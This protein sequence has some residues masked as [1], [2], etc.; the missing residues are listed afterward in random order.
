MSLLC[1][2][3]ILETLVVLLHLHRTCE[4]QAEENGQRIQPQIGEVPRRKNLKGYCHCFSSGCAVPSYSIESQSGLS[5]IRNCVPV[6][7]YLKRCRIV[8]AKRQILCRHFHEPV[9]MF[10]RRVLFTLLIRKKYDNMVDTAKNRAPCDEPAL[11]LN[12]EHEARMIIQNPIIAQ[13][14]FY[15]FIEGFK[16]CSPCCSIG[17]LQS[18]LEQKFYHF[19]ISRIL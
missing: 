15:H 5:S 13:S 1:S 18:F 8:V 10:V 7:M 2:H 12:S 6:R 9:Q 14:V 19:P 17:I 16:G 11:Y 3:T 4:F